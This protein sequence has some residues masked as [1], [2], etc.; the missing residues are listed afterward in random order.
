MAFLVLRNMKLPA[1]GQVSAGLL[2]RT[3]QAAVG[4]SAGAVAVLVSADG[5]AIKPL[6]KK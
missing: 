4:C 3:A 1:H 2:P 6:P 5:Q